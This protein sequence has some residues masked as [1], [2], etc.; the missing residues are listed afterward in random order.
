MPF[1]RIPRIAERRI[2]RWALA[3]TLLVAGGLFVAVQPAAYADTVVFSDDFTDGDLSGWVRSGGT[4]SVAPDGGNNALQQTKTGTNA[5]IFA[6]SNSWT[7]YRLQARVKPLTLDSNGFVGLLARVSGLTTFYRLALLPTKVVQ[8]QAVRGGGVTVLGQAT[9][10]V[11]T[12]TWYTLALDVTGT[13]VTGFVNGAKVAQATSSTIASGRI[14]VQASQATGEFDDVVV[15]TPVAPTPTAPP[16]TNPPTTP[17]TTAPPT[18]APPTT[19]P[20]TTTPPTTTAPPTTTPSPP[21]TTGTTVTVAADGSGTFTTVQAAVDSV[22]A[23]N[24]K[25]FS[26]GIKPGDYHELVTVPQNKP[27]ISFI[28]LGAKPSDVVIEFDNASGTLKADGTQLGTGNSA[29]VTITG[30]DFVAQNLTFANTFDEAAHPEITNQQAVA[31]QTNGDRLTFDNVRFLGN[32]DTLLANTPNT[33][34]VSRAY[35]HNCYIEGDVDFI[36]GRG[37][38]VFDHCEI[39]SLDRGST[40]NN[41]YV[42]AASTS[43]TNTFGFLFSQCNLTSS[44][45]AGTVFLGRPWH[46]NNDPDAIAQVVFRDST[47]GPQIKTSPWTDM[48]GFSWMDARFDEFDNSGAGSTI[49]A[50][51]PQLTADQAAADTPQ[52]YLAGS[53]SWNPIA[54]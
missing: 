11:T 33:S 18:T 37:T 53:D 10:Q 8:L 6:G 36:F 46:P 32:Q 40:S 19:T 27:F 42:T 39:H 4:W 15:T 22:P 25:R 7:D 1:P 5:R 49:T 31:V 23:N 29:S 17:P 41:G 48:S 21:T 52:A 14:G 50:D 45:A 12:G 47:L 9:M 24:T 44:A 3:A 26:I 35:Y 54:S 38:A 34:T 51:R 28:G 2:R 13:T 43:D 20:P 30:H 16:T